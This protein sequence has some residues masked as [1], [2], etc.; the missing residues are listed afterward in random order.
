MNLRQ[1]S[2]FCMGF[3][4][5]T[6]WVCAVARRAYDRGYH[7]GSHETICYVAARTGVHVEGCE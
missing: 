1:I 6:L 2:F 3:G 7:D 4:I 5:V